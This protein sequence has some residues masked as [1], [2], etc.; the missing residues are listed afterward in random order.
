MAYLLLLSGEV[1][2]RLYE[3]L[4]ARIEV[5]PAGIVGAIDG[6]LETWA[7]LKVDIDL[8]VLA[9]LIGGDIRTNGGS[10]FFAEV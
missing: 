1:V 4:D 5:S 8:A 2:V 10:E 3:T 6:V 9:G 7:E